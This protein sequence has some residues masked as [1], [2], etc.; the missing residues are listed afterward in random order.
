MPGS[1]KHLFAELTVRPGLLTR[2]ADEAD[3]QVDRLLGAGVAVDFINSHEHVHLL[4]HL[5]QQRHQHEER[6][7]ARAQ[8]LRIWMLV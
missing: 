3:A 6:L 1:Y 2:I 5:S 7:F 4:T 8:E